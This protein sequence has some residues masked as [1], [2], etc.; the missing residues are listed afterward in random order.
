MCTDL[1][2]FFD[3]T[4]LKCHSSLKYTVSASE[5]LLCFQ[6][7]PQVQK[8]LERHTLLTRTAVGFLHTTLVVRPGT[9]R[10]SGACEGDWFQR[11]L[12]ARASS[13]SSW[14]DTSSLEFVDP[15][16]RCWKVCRIRETRFLA[17]PPP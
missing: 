7:E 1:H 15:A 8:V 6:I 2:S 9:W 3:R 12:K 4:I 14:I 13:A 11:L 16:Q 17:I 10:F 5:I